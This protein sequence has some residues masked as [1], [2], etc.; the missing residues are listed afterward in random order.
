MYILNLNKTGTWTMIYDEGFN[1]DFPEFTFF[2]FSKYTIEDEFNGRKV[3]KSQCYSTC[4]GWYSNKDKTKWGCYQAFK[5]GVE[6]NKVTYINSKN[7]VNI[8]QPN[9]KNNDNIL[10]S[11]FGDMNFKQVKTSSF[12]AEQVLESSLLKLD[13][14]FN[15]H[16][17][18][19]AKLN[20]L[21]K[22]WDAAVY[23][24]FSHMTLGQMNKF[25]GFPR[26][27]VVSSTY[28]NK[29]TQ[30]IQQQDLSMFPE[31]F[32]WKKLLRPAGS[33]GNCGSCYAFSTTRMIEARL[34]LIYNHE[35]NLSVQHALD[36]SFYNQGC[37]GGYPF[38]V[39]KFANEFEMIT[40][41]CKPYTEVDGKC[42]Q[43]T[44]NIKQL[45]FIYRVIN[46]KYIGGSY[47]ACNESLMMEELYKN[48]P[49]V[50]SFE[51][52]YN[53]MMYKSGIYHSLQSDSWI[54]QGLPKPEWEK[55]DHSILLVGWGVDKLSGEKFW[56]LQNTWGPNWGENGF[57]RI[58]RGY[59]ELAIESICESAIP[60]IIDNKTNMPIVLSSGPGR[61]TPIT[62][63]NNIPATYQID[64]SMPHSE[65]G[66]L[67]SIFDSTNNN[68]K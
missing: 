28:E 49:F 65:N 62:S 1:V 5:G 48:G 10:S 7:N 42:N 38:L 57:F 55:V 47:G 18:Y 14:K 50:V 29:N 15:K 9:T 3:Y 21:K 17:L 33:Q 20:T 32:D 31:S 8:V 51:P 66:P 53:F 23:P 37:D 56:M 22:N 59:D 26:F 34:K 24:E 27:K 64:N 63:G 4:V 67:S 2:A 16:D 52:D 46:Y 60:I 58:K 41:V 30:N 6:P 68:Y 36:C 44:C 43:N 12:L 13:A 35:V 40:E 61:F 19:V 11:F 39:M 45:P 25:A 54:N